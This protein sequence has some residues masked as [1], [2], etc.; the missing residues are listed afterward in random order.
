[1]PV[2][3]AVARLQRMSVP[4]FAEAYEGL[5][6]IQGVLS[7]DGQCLR[8]SFHTTDA[9][10]G[11][12]KSKAQELE[13]DLD[14]VEDIEFGLGWFWLLP[15]LQ[16][17]LND[18]SLLSKVPAA[19]HGR[20]RLRVRFADRHLAR[21]FGEQLRFARAEHLHHAIDGSLPTEARPASTQPPPALPVQA[22][23]SPPASTESVVDPTADGQRRVVED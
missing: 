17:R 4:V 1:M 19:K 11:L 12:L 21:R 13:L 16:F 22:P 3:S 5:G 9:L 8:L 14:S 2:D 15:Y 6:D 23:S 20:L 7:Y 10:F 18:F